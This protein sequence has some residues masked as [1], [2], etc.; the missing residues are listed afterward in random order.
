M[1]ALKE[2]KMHLKLKC[3]QAASIFNKN[4]E[5]SIFHD[6]GVDIWLLIIEAG[7]DNIKCKYHLQGR[8]S[9][10]QDFFNTTNIVDLT[11]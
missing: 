8:L 11:F 3:V 2:S 10:R 5:K 6:N 1:A 4:N 7:N 9:R